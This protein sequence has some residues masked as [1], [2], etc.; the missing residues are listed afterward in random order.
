MG[1]LW[2]QKLKLYDEAKVLDT[3]LDNVEA[4][5]RFIVEGGGEYPRR[6]FNQKPVMNLLAR[7]RGYFGYPAGVNLAGTDTFVEFPVPMDIGITEL[8]TA[9]EVPADYVES[10][11]LTDA[12]LMKILSIQT[13]PRARG[14]K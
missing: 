6:F 12:E 7:T 5:N 14:K 4:V 8:A 1:N 11:M 2:Y 3:W 9:K 13:Q 10:R